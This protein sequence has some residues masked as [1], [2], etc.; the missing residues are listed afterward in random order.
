MRSPRKLFMALIL[1][2]VFSPVHAEE[3]P[4]PGRADRRIRTVVYNQNNVVAI[5]ATFGTSTLI[6]LDPEEKIQTLGLG[7]AMAW[8]VEPNGAGNLLFLKPVEKDAGS[9]LNIVT[10]KR[11]YT[12]ALRSNNNPPGS[13]IYKV[14]FQYPEKDAD[15]QMMAEARERARYPNLKNMNV[16]NLNSAYGYKGSSVNKPDA[17]YDDGTKTWFR[18]SGPVPSIYAVDTERNEALVNYR[19]EGD[20]IVVDKVNFQWT[21]RSGTDSTCVFN[22][23]LRNTH[24]PT[25]LEPTAPKLV[26]R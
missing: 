20:Y 13:Q 16:A 21:L 4:V 9:N 5:D 15:N 8:K 25:G 1:S 17:V 19:R 7:D 3:T 23:R 24:Q 26:R 6:V 22:Q 14:V 11:I 2:A 18:F 10:D 12:L